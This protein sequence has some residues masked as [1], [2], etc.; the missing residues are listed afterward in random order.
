MI[1]RTL[2]RWMKG[3]DP[4][5]TMRRYQVR[6]GK[7]RLPTTRGQNGGLP[8]LA[9]T[10]LALA[11][12]AGELANIVK[13]VY[14]DHGGKITPEFRQKLIDEVGDV[15][16]YVAQVCEDLDADLD[17]VAERNLAKLRE[18]HSNQGR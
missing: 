9:Y 3:E 12:E 10:A 6:S 5:L 11:G 18:R 8:G 15:L 14:R 1:L 16:W 13:K 2:L 4:G 7:T 17:E